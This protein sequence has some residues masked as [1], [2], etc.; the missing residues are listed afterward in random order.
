[1]RKRIS[2]V[3]F[4]WIVL[5]LLPAPTLAQEW[6]LH[7]AYWTI[8]LQKDI[9]TTPPPHEPSDLRWFH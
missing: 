6:P 1:M 2:I 8:V 3:M 4:F 5:A 7:N 9:A